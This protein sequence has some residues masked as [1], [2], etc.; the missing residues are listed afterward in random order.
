[1]NSSIPAGA[2]AVLVSG[3]Y[4]SRWLPTSWLVKELHYLPGRLLHC[5]YRYGGT[6]ITLSLVIEATLLAL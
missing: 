1:M 4:S 2:A 3:Y 6:I 5:R